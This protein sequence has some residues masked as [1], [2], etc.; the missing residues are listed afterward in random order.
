MEGRRLQ[1]ASDWQRTSMASILSEIEMIVL[2]SHLETFWG[3]FIDH[4][5][6]LGIS[7][8]RVET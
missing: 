6:L 3:I 1:L 5:V 8:K 7:L 4:R 2:R